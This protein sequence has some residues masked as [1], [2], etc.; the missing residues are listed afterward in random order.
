MKYAKCHVRL[1]KYGWGITELIRVDAIEEHAAKPGIKG[2][3][4]WVKYNGPLGVGPITGSNAMLGMYYDINMGAY[5]NGHLDVGPGPSALK[6]LFDEG[7]DW[8][9]IEHSHAPSGFI[10]KVS[11]IE[12]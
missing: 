7:M 2:P 6:K 8:I 9:F 3:F 11:M 10:S 4:G 5:Y 12:G 1:C